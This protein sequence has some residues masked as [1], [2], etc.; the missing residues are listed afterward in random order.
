[1][2]LLNI[3]ATA[4]PF[5]SD[6][7]DLAM[8]RAHNL[9]DRSGIGWVL[10]DSANRL[11][12]SGCAISG[13]DTSS[14]PDTINKYG[15]RLHHLMMTIEPVSGALNIQQLL[16][17]LTASECEKMTIAHPINDDIADA[18]WTDWKAKWHGEVIALQPTMTSSNL[19]S[20]VLS[21]KSKRRP[22]VTAINSVNFKN[23]TIPLIDC[24]QEFGAVA[25]LSS[26]ASQCRAVLHSPCQV[27]I[28]E[29]LPPTNK[30]DELIERFEI[31]TVNTC[32]KVLSYCADEYR[33]HVLIL[34]DNQLLSKMLARNY[35]DEIIHHTKIGCHQTAAKQYDDEVP[36]LEDWD[37]VASTTVGNCNRITL[38]KHKHLAEHPIINVQNYN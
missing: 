38:K 19:A 21:V 18:Q 34:C 31:N 26:L 3:S 13:V 30:V 36:N 33:C 22:W 16:G 8:T 10:L 23:Q 20:G 27:G 2:K 17:S 32:E 9:S 15:S 6:A 28:L 1:M 29:H 24:S 12:T 37:L 5:R 4:K 7:L 25:Y 35:V 11:L 14:L